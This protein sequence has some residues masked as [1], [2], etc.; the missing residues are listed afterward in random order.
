VTKPKSVFGPWVDIRKRAMSDKRLEEQWG[1]TLKQANVWPTIYWFEWGRPGSGAFNLQFETPND[2]Y[3]DADTYMKRVQKIVRALKKLGP[4]DPPRKVYTNEG[5]LI[6]PNIM[7]KPRHM[8]SLGF[9]SQLER[10]G[11]RLGWEAEEGNGHKYL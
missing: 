1:P 3:L 5:F 6:V 10:I 9:A 4:I 2:G 7:S 8:D 11:G